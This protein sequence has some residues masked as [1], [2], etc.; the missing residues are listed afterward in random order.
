MQDPDKDQEKWT[1]PKKLHAKIHTGK[2]V[3]SNAI[4]CDPTPETQQPDF[5]LTV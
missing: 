3:V 4:V 5:V 2:L 1:Q